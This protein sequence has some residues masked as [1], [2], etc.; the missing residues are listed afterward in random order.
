MIEP[1]F[2]FSFVLDAAAGSLDASVGERLGVLAA[3]VPASGAAVVEG[4]A[5]V[6]VLA[7]VLAAAGDAPEPFIA[8][9]LAVA[10]M[11]GFAAP[12]VVVLVST[13]VLVLRLP[14]SPFDDDVAASPPPAP[15]A[16][17]LAGGAEPLAV[18]DE[19]LGF[20]S[21]TG[22]KSVTVGGG[23]FSLS[24]AMVMLRGHASSAG[25]GYHQAGE[26]RWQR[27]RPPRGGPQ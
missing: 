25:R 20:S 1:S 13:L 17:A 6:S 7:D 23:A 21:V 4:E 2:S 9:G 24:A 8:V 10:V 14:A 3:A 15:A 26:A 16:P 19:S 5:A 11:P 18:D 12:V 22:L 27:G